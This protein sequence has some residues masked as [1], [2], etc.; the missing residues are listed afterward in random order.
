[1]TISCHSLES[2]GSPKH[3]ETRFHFNFERSSV[4]QAIEEVRTP[5]L[6]L[7]LSK[8]F[9]VLD[10]LLIN[11]E[12]ET[13]IYIQCTV[14]SHHPV[15]YEALKRIF[16]VLDKQFPRYSHSLVFFIPQDIFHLFKKQSYLNNDKEERSRPSAL[17]IHQ[18]K[19]LSNLGVTL[20][21]AMPSM[22]QRKRKKT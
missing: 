7:P 6:Y 15:K 22:T 4:I 10:A 18:Y 11:A 8:S 14:S 9:P 21:D 17:R 12:E 20:V 13:I 16:D 5:G 19:C 3:K 1:M 2:E